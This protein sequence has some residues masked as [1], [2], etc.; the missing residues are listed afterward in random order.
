MS[1]EIV[2]AINAVGLQVDI[3]GGEIKVV[4]EILTGNGDTSKGVV[5]RQIVV[6]S[7]LKNMGTS[8]QGLADGFVECQDKRDER[9]AQA[10][11]EYISTR[12]WWVG[13]VLVLLGLSVAVMGLWVK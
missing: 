12:R 9:I 1:E 6:E 11:K 2:G 7:T 3:L 13:T 4:K 8:M 5:A 10:R